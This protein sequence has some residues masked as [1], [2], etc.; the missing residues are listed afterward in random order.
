MG[1]VNKLDKDKCIRGSF[2]GRVMFKK[3]Y[4]MGLMGLFDFMVVNRRQAWNMSTT[5]HDDR[6]V[7]AMH[8]FVWHWQWRC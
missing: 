7:S 3:W 1:G 2:T 4:R 5:I 6:Y 8:I